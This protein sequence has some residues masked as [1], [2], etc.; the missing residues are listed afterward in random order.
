MHVDLPENDDHGKHTC[1]PD[2][3]KRSTRP[4]LHLPWACESSG[5]C[6][7]PPSIANV[8]A[9]APLSDSL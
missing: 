9:T 8:T 4:P 1:P 5:W 7:V 2:L 6:D 3:L